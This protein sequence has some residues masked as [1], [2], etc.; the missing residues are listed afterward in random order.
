[1]TVK[2]CTINRLALGGHRSR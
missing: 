1:M 2:S